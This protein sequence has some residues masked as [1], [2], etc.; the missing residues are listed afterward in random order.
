[1]AFVPSATVTALGA[2]R[3]AFVC[4]KPAVQAVPAAAA[5][6]PGRA[7]CPRMIALPVVGDVDPL[8]ALLTGGEVAIAGAVGVIIFNV[9]SGL[10]ASVNAPPP[11][12]TAPARRAAAESNDGILGLSAL[13]PE[14][15]KKRVQV[16]MKTSTP[17]K[18]DNTAANLAALEEQAKA[19][20]PKE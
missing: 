20:F 15:T 6:R 16:A 1:M 13:K 3:S 5:T 19:M 9:A 17:V 11:E 10:F 18:R 2:S 7:S 12:D 4:A 8:S 14:Q